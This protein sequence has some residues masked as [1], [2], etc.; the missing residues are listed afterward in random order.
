M[1]SHL[2]GSGQ[3]SASLVSALSKIMKKVE[4][5][6]LLEAHMVTLKHSC[7]TWME[8]E[9]TEIESDHPTEEE[10]AAF[11]EAERKHDDQFQALETLASRFSQSLGVGKLSDA[12]LS[13][14][15]LGFLREGVRFSFWYSL[16]D[17]WALGSRLVFLNIIGKYVSWIR[18]NKEHKEIIQQ[19]LE[20]REVSQIKILS[21]VV[22]LILSSCITH[23]LISYVP[24]LD[25]SFYR[26]LCR[27]TMI[28]PKC[29]AMTLHAWQTFVKDLA[30]R[31][32]T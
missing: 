6:R 29:T 27:H 31:Q 24:S 16:E 15:L 25:S 14:A 30:S 10:M 17:G 19:E 9:P 4:P 2:T 22:L 32:M 23:E 1:L 11:D 18:R 12:R 13:S 28:F 5:V 20:N 8:N 21:I 26:R 7:E 3:E